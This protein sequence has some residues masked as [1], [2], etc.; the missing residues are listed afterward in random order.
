MQIKYDNVIINL[1][2][3]QK[4]I[5]REVLTSVHILRGERSYK[6]NKKKIKDTLEKGIRDEKRKQGEKKQV[7]IRN[8]EKESN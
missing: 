5:D 3:I 8:K 4:R 6:K 7:I 1:Q 2:Q